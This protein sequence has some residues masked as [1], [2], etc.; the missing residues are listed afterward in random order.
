MPN[1]SPG[2]PRHPAYPSGHSTYGGA[3]SELLSYFFPDY[4]EE[5]DRLADNCGMARLWAGIHWRSDHVQGMRLGR[6]VA[7]MVIE[8][9]EQSCICPADGCPPPDPC[10]LPPDDDQLRCCGRETAAGG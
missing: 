3:A 1:P 6:C 7:R 2:T 8:Q 10:A 9:L 4:S 5:L